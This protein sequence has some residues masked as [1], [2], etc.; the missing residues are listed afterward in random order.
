MRK[1]VTQSL[2]PLGPYGNQIL[3]TGDNWEQAL[4]TH[5][6]IGLTTILIVT[7]LINSN[8]YILFPK[9]VGWLQCGGSGNIISVNLFTFS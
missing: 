2:R 4:R 6:D 8:Q 9:L 5:P 1:I 3:E 7:T